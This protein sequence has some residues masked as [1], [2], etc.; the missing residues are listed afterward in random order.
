MCEDKEIYI[1]KTFENNITGFKG[2]LINTFQNA[3]REFQINFLRYMFSV[4]TKPDF[5]ENHFSNCAL[6]YDSI[7]ATG[8]KQQKRIST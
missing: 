6:F 3:K 4:G 5:C 1:G 7:K 2:K 8:C